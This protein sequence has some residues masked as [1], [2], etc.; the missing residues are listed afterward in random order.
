L[1]KKIRA[2][3]RDLIAV[4]RLKYNPP[5]RAGAEMVLSFLI[6]GQLNIPPICRYPLLH[7][8]AFRFWNIPGFSFPIADSFEIL[9]FDDTDHGGKIDIGRRRKSP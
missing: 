3:E 6:S 4:C 8:E 2:Q 7:S 9:I 1:G 5:F